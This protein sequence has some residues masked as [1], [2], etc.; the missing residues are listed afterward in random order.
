MVIKRYYTSDKNGRPKQWVTDIYKLYSE[1][2]GN[3]IL[4]YIFNQILV[5]SMH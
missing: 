4:G 3:V 5:T 1:L 2:Y